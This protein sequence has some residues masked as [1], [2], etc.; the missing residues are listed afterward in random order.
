MSDN[1]STA[2]D[3]FVSQKN[4]ENVHVKYSRIKRKVLRHV[5][6][7]RIFIIT[8]LIVCLGSI[9]LIGSETI[10]DLGVGNASDIASSFVF[11]DNQALQSDK[12]RSNILVMGVGG[13]GH[14]G[15]ELTDTMLLVSISLEKNNVEVISV[16]RDVWIPQIRAKINSAYYWGNQKSAGGG[17]S[18]AKSSIQD[19]L[20]L[21]PQYAVLVDFSG[22][23]SIVDELGGIDVNVEKGF[24]DPLYPITGKENDLCGGDK[25]YA[26]RYESI[27]FSP[28]VQKMNGETALKFVRSR[29]A[30]GDEGTDIARQSRQQKIIDAIKNKFLTPSVFLNPKKI[31]SVWKAVLN[32]VETDIDANTIAL[33]AR[34]LFDSRD[35]IDTNLIPSDLLINP[36]ITPTYD[37][38][39]VFIPR[40]GNG[41]WKEINSWVQGIVGQ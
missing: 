24:T 16:P 15:S 37:K 11:P 32:S 39:Y 21:K 9:Y 19:V 27:S 3:V 38:Q 6:L 41:N 2:E 33:M 1:S 7:V 30:E 34:K 14:E 8:L 40:A 10:K 29:H 4:N 25:T 5:W 26:C 35:S 18:L 12:G 17:L 23:K 13:K 36:P 20:G 31:V 22:F 28:G